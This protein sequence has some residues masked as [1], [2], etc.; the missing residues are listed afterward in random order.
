MNNFF[1]SKKIPVNEKTFRYLRFERA[2][3]SIAIVL[4]ALYYILIKGEEFLGPH[5]VLVIVDILI[6]SYG[7][8]FINREANKDDE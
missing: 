1:K 7:Q 3:I 4:Y 8:I 6:S 5:F 2:T